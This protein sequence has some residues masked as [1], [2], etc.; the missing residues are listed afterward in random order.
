MHPDYDTPKKLYRIWNVRT[1]SCV[2][3]GVP[4]SSPDEALAAVPAAT[5]RK[6][7]YL[8]ARMDPG[9]EGNHGEFG[10]FDVAPP[11][12]LVITKATI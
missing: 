4:A 2:D 9:T 1:G 11:K 7:R 8:V 3:S 10:I 5:I 12:T 6:S